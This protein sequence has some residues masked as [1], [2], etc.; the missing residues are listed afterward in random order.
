MKD[1]TSL[2]RRTQ[3]LIDCFAGT[4]PLKEMSELEKREDPVPVFQYRVSLTSIQ[5]P[6]HQPFR[7]SFNF[8]FAS[9]LR[10]LDGQLQR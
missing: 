10:F 5:I 1:K 2:H 3:E 4:D 8:D 6:L 7:L 9:L